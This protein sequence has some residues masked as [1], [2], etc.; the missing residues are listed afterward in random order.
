MGPRTFAFVLAFCLLGVPGARA[1][2]IEVRV[3]V[4][5]Q[6]PL[7]SSAVKRISVALPKVADVRIIEGEI[8]VTGRSEGKT[9]ILVWKRSGQLVS[10][11][12]TVVRDG[13]TEGT[14]ELRIDVG[15]QKLLDITGVKTLSVGDPKIAD[16]R[17][18]GGQLVV[19]GRAV[20]NTTL[21][22]WKRNRQRL[23]YSVLVRKD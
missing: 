21:L 20:G 12:V 3:G 4:G 11:Q 6:R 13:S 9:S 5:M 22:I 23:G 2:E 17:V 1:E 16:V 15:A 10:Y 7:G 8:V 19:T 14:E 18:V